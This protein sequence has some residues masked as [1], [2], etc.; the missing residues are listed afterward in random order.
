M[1]IIPINPPIEVSQE[2]D[3]FRN[4]NVIEEVQALLK[5]T[6]DSVARIIG[7]FSPSDEACQS[8]LGSKNEFKTLAYCP[9][10]LTLLLLQQDLRLWPI[11]CTILLFMMIPCCWNWI[12]GLESPRVHLCHCQHHRHSHLLLL[13]PQQDIVFMFSPSMTP[14]NK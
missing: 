11:V 6:C 2:I 10:S 5:D 8:P 12:L 1:P 7:D 14:I 3:S 4:F 13:L 9:L